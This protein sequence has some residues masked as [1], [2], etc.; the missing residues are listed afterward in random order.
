LTDAT[1]V[2]T[3]LRPGATRTEALLSPGEVDDRPRHHLITQVPITPT[4]LEALKALVAESRDPQVFTHRDA[5]DARLTRNLEQGSTEV[6]E[7]A[8]DETPAIA[9]PT[10]VEAQVTGAGY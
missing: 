6:A 9:G 5:L 1:L 3:G 10:D 7:V 2:Y 8:A 4:A